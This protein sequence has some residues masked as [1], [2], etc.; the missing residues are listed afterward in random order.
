[1]EGKSG[2]SSRGKTSSSSLFCSVAVK[3]LVVRFD[4]LFM[5]YRPMF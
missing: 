4:N 1:M 2:V 3:L 5:I